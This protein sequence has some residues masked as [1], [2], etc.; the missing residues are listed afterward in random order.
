MN[1]HKGTT[2]ENFLEEENL[3]SHTQ[4]VA[5]ERVTA[6][7]IHTLSDNQG[8]QYDAIAKQFANMRDSFNTEQKYIDLL[9]Q[10]LQPQAHILDVG[11]GSG[12]PIAAYLIEKGFQVT[13]LD[14]SKELLKIAEEKCPSMKRIYCDVRTVVLEEKYDAII[15]W[16]CL[17]HLPKEDQ[18]KMISRFAHWLKKDGIVEF[19]TGD[20]EYE[21]KNSDMLNQELCFYSHKPITY[22]KVLKKN[23]FEILLKESDQET[24]LVWIV[25]YVG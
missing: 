3:L 10:Y 17:F 11:C 4:A 12:Y 14:G 19:T 21:G 13:G 9:I 1:Q 23:G 7:Q 20:H 22:E 5:V 25:K 15:E 16:W 8:K 2:F 18:L 24:H 6:Y